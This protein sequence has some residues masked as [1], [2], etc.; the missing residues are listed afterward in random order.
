MKTQRCSRAHVLPAARPAVA[1]RRT[2]QEDR[3]RRG[4]LF[5][6]M[7]KSTVMGDQHS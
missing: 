6:M 7:A 2:L 1:R 5:V 4:D 3:G